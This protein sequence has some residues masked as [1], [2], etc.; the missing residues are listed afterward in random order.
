MH[1]STRHLLDGP[2]RLLQVFDRL[3]SL[4]NRR[5]REVPAV[6]AQ[7]DALLTLAPVQGFRHMW[8]LGHTI[9]A[10]PWPY[11]TRARR[12]WCSSARIWRL[13]WPRGRSWCDCSP[14]PASVVAAAGPVRH[15]PGYR[16]APDS[17]AADPRTRLADSAWRAGPP[18]VTLYHL[19]IDLG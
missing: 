8:G 2:M 17:A 9:G 14:Q 3:R 12:I 13:S 4:L 15:G 11:G 19:S 18:D 7:A 6:Q 5:R 1:C 16:G 10:G